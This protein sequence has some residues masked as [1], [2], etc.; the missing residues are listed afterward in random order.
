MSKYLKNICKH[1]LKML[2]S[3]NTHHSRV[4]LSTL[5]EEGESTKSFYKSTRRKQEITGQKLSTNTKHKKHQYRTKELRRK[6]GLYNES[7]VIS[8]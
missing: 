7:N 2:F 4:V 5:D 6:R 3:I 8:E 1:R